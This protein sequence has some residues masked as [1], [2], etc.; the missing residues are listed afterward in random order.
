MSEN[1]YPDMQEL[2]EKYKLF[3]KE[4]EETISQYDENDLINENRSLK[5]QSENCLLMIKELQNELNKIKSE[6][7]GLK[8]SVNE[9]IINEK[10][11]ILRASKDKI[12]DYFKDKTH[13]M[14]NSLYKLER[15]TKDKIDALTRETST[16]I[17]ND[18]TEISNEISTLE[19]K[20]K[21]KSTNHK[22]IIDGKKINLENKLKVAY[23]SLG[24][25]P[26]SEKI[27]QKRLKHNN[28]E[29]KFGLSWLNWIGAFLILLSIVNFAKYSYS[30]WFTD[31]TKGI[32]IFVL[33]L[34]FLLAGEKLIKKKLT[35]FGKGFVSLGI[36]SLY[37]ST[38]TSYFLLNIINQTTVLGMS[39]AV[40]FLS[41]FMVQRHKSRTV[42]VFA[43]IGGYLP[44]IFYHFAISSEIFTS[45]SM[46]VYVV[47]INFVIMK[48]SVYKEWDIV[49]YIGF[50]IGI[51]S[52]LL[53]FNISN[54]IGV[55][56]IYSLITFTMFVAMFTLYPIKNRTFKLISMEVILLGFNTLITCSS[57][58]LLIQASEF[59]NYKGI[60]SLFYCLFYY[61]LSRIVQSLSNG[62]SEATDTVWLFNITAI[63]F[64]FMIIPFQFG[65]AWVSL[66]WIIES[67]VLII[68]GLRSNKK[69]LEL[70]GWVMYV[71][72]YLYLG[73]ERIGFSDSQYIHANN[74]TLIVSL[75]MLMYFYFKVYGINHFKFQAKY[76]ALKVFKY[77][78]LFDI[79]RYV[80]TEGIYFFDKYLRS[81]IPDASFYLLIMIVTVIGAYPYILSKIKCLQDTIIEWI[82]AI[83]LTIFCFSMLMMNGIFVLIS[84][85]TVKIL[86]LILLLIYNYIAFIAFRKVSFFAVYAGRLN[87][88]IFPLLESIYM[89]LLSSIFVSKQFEWFAYGHFLLTLAIMIYAFLFIRYG[90][91]KK[92]IYIRRFGLS[93]S[94]FACIKLLL[95]DLSHLN[96]LWRIISFFVLGGICMGI[97]YLYQRIS[98][99]YQETETLTTTQDKIK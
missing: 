28:I 93:L 63:I 64:S 34:L 53:T 59:T 10:L 26:V 12:N 21:A 14:D 30:N 36:G 6:N 65:Q 98:R 19:Q 16:L 81:N 38:F 61:G 78:A 80:I 97:S 95:V 67:V 33:S 20:L 52:Y 55:N 45:I 77:I 48:T 71:I 68:F 42:S 29:F 24:E 82:T 18:K 51:F 5:K 72:S 46:I 96:T 1:K 92:Y 76:N 69:I 3:S 25:E 94:F 79:F 41:V 60:L 90:F 8:Q 83:L 84:I 4:L 35:T 22:N 44:I 37:I 89:L 99:S 50:G 31:T 62:K 73:T 87:Y 17:E 75:I 11:V 56:L 47:L 23:T 32:S 27:I 66:G 13:E 85:S 58:Y 86:P 88:E 39:V 74:A 7:V 54:N 2:M 15:D 70:F 49:K 57:S 43:I 40:A 91:A 9:Q